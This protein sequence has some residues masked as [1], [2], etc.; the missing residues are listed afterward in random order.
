MLENAAEEQVTHK[1]LDIYS[2][3]LVQM[4]LAKM[5]IEEQVLAPA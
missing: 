3:E 1:N 2:Q 5:R 4:C